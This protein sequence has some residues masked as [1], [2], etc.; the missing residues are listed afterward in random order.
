MRA[1]WNLG[2]RPFF[3]FGGMWS[4]LHV[5]LWVLFQAGWISLPLQD[6]M[7]WHAHEMIFGFASAMVAGFLLTASQNWTGIQ[8]VH[9]KKLKILVLLWI[10]ARVLSVTNENLHGVYAL[11][12][13]SFYPMLGW[14][15]KPYLANSVQKRNWI[16]LFLFFV[17][18][19]ANLIIHNA[20]FQWFS[21]PDPRA[22]LL[23]SMYAIVMMISV[24]G[25]RVI[26]FFTNNAVPNTNPF[27]HPLLEK[28]TEMSIAVSAL[29]VF[30][31]EF[32][33]ITALLCGATAIIHLLRWFFWKPWKSRSVPIL[34]ILY[35]GYLWIPIGF[36]LRALASASMILP[37][38]STHAF[39]AGAIGTMIYGMTT[40]VALGH[41]GRPIRA[42]RWIVAGY[43]AIVLCAVIRVFGPLFDPAH[44]LWHIQVSGLLWFFAFALFTAIYAPILTQPRA[45]G[46]NG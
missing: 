26:P 6:P 32:S 12:D 24:I 16:F 33:I 42:S 9:G 27:R 18:F 37:S 39:T 41:S 35:V 8:G 30:V 4:A 5:L 7:V 3:L 29:A 22:T 38:S 15:L 17:L 28:F 10:S 40:R 45:D 2:F 1:L 36:V 34:W 20:Y 44:Y 19:L 43:V 31:H 21:L 13:L 23:L 11:V 14:Y 46:K 25:G